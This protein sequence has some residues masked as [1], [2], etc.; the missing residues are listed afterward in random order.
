ME[1]DIENKK[2][3]Y[4]IVKCPLKSVLKHY[5]K[6]QPIIENAVIDINDIT[7]LGYQFIK[8]YMLSKF[9]KNEEFPKLNKQFV[10]DVLKTVSS[11][12][13]NR[14]KQKKNIKN[15][16][17][18][19]EIKL[20]YKDIFSRLTDEKLSYTNKSHIL[21]QEALQMI[22]CINTNISTHF[23]EYLFKYINCVFKKPVVDEI[24][25]LET[26]KQIYLIIKLKI[27][28]RN[29]ING[30]KIIKNYYFQPR[31]TKIFHM[32]LKSILIN[33]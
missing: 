13:T 30:L 7:I 5:D 24:K 20:F 1:Q 3:I 21:E 15:E 8:L 23:L 29:I 25:K 26:L 10:L 18:K 16:N 28:I 9:N 11:A 17:T 33:I 12:K 6:I 19:S 27:L 22:T 2:N 14:G 4:R 31:L 32:M